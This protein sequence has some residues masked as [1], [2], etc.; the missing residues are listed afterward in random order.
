MVA[1]LSVSDLNFPN[2]TVQHF[3]SDAVHH[4]YPHGFMRLGGSG[5][6]QYGERAA[7]VF[8]AAIACLISRQE[9]SA[10]D[11]DV[12]AASPQVLFESYWR[13]QVKQEGY[14]CR[15]FTAR[16]GDVLI[17]HA[18]LLHGGSAVKNK[19]LSR[20]SQV[21]HYYFEGCVLHRYGKLYAQPE[22][23][24]WHS[25]PSISLSGD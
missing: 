10:S 13:D 24:Q 5:R 19:R 8:R 21:S 6:H 17:W 20:W 11:A 2:G 18:N 1:A 14:P 15:L 7:G 9:I 12:K 3:H 4:A 22:G 16:K 23:E 25:S